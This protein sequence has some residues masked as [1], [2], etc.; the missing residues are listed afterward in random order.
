LTVTQL[1]KKIPASY[2]TGRFI[3]VPRGP[4]T[5]LY[6]ETDESNPH[7]LGLLP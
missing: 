1:V 5:D 6:P 3:T 2:G 7:F 4:A